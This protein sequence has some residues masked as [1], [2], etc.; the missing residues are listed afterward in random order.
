M[1][2][3]NM[4]MK[5][6][7]EQLEN[8]VKAKDILLRT[9]VILIGGGAGLSVS[10]GIDY[11]DESLVKKWF[12]MYHKKGL[13]TIFRIQREFWKLSD[14]NV[15]IY[16]GYWARHIYHIRY[17]LKAT[18]PYKQLY[19]LF[20]NKDYFICTTNVESQFEKAGFKKEKIFNPQGNY[21]Y[22]QCSKLCHDTLY[23]NEETIRNMINNMPNDFEIKKEDI[24]YCPKCGAYFIPNLRID[25]MFAEKPNLWNIK[26]YQS[27]LENAYKY[28]TFV[29]LELGVGYSTPGIIRFPFENIAYSFDNAFLIRVNKK[30]GEVPKNIET[31]SIS[32]DTD[33]DFFLT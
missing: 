3:K 2:L 32:V 33:I 25:D 7:K 23:Y 5:Y 17:E 10:G 18:Y 30:H 19:Q 31:K 24:P 11:D 13:K 26:E 20:K 12:P 15:L 4:T 16:W 14:K 22:F 29:I 27:F 9:D 8:V 6:T 28:K 21:A 1:Y